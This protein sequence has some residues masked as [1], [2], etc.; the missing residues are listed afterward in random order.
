MTWNILAVDDDKDM[1]FLLRTT[2]IRKGFDVTEA[3][4][5]RAALE[6]VFAS[7]PH[8]VLMDVMM[9]NMDGFAACEVIRSTK[10]TAHIPVILLSALSARQYKDKSQESGASAYLTKPVPPTLLVEIIQEVL[11]NSYN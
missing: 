1:L 7:P 3:S 9:P 4:D 11:E 6:Q 10:S 8:L 5:G 2:L